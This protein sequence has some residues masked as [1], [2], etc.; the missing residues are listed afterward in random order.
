MVPPMAPE[1]EAEIYLATM[2]KDARAVRRYAEVAERLGWPCF[3]MTWQEW[4]E[5]VAEQREAEAE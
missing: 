1:M 4:A 3:G 2:E 5:A